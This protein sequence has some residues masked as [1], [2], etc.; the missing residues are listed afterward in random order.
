MVTAFEPRFGAPAV[1]RGRYQL[2]AGSQTRYSARAI[3][4]VE[5]SLTI[6][7]LNQFRFPDFADKPPLSTR[8]L[9]QPGSFTAEQFAVYRDSGIKVFALGHGASDYAAGIK[10]FA[11][12]NGFLAGYSDWLIR[13]DD[14]GDFERVRQPGKVGI[15][16]TFQGSDHFRPRRCR[17]LL[18]A[19][20]ARLTT[21]LQLRQSDRRGVPGARRRRPD[22][23]RRTDRRA[24]ER[25]RHGRRSLPLR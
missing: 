19:G 8:W 13:I 18:V 12:W 21:D 10:Y 25:G 17:H 1:L 20:P 16:L 11:D 7:M 14:L 9:Q 5:G 23:L 6:D 24:H 2:F 22:G 15:M 4:L 3:K